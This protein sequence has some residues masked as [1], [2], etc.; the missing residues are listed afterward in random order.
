MMASAPNV[1]RWVAQ[2]PP[3]VTAKSVQIPGRIGHHEPDW[4]KAQK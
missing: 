4:P 1:H 2:K 3:I